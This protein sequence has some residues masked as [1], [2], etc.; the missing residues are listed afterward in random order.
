MTPGGPSPTYD[1]YY[2][3]LLGYA[4]KL[5]ATAKDNTLSQKANSVESDYLAQ[6][7]LLDLCYNN[8]TNLLTYVSNQGDDIDMIQDVFPCHQVMNERRLCLPSRTHREPTCDELQI[9]N[10]TWSELQDNTKS[11]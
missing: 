4:K 6:H 2:K 5:E 9:Q 3:Q 8:G 1:E 7:S 11:D 10:L